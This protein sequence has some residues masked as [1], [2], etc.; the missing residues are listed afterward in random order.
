GGLGKL[1]RPAPDED[2]MPTL[3]PRAFGAGTERDEGG[4]ADSRGVHGRPGGKRRHEHR[5]DGVCFSHVA[6]LHPRPEVDA[7]SLTEGLPGPLDVVEDVR[8]RAA[9]EGGAVL[10]APAHERVGINTGALAPVSRSKTMARRGSADRLK[11]I[12]GADAISDTEPIEFDEHLPNGG[13][14]Q[15]FLRRPAV[16]GIAGAVMV[17]ADPPFGKPVNALDGIHRRA[18]GNRGDPAAVGVA[19]MNAPTGFVGRVDDLLPAL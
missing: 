6:H 19:R 1:R 13:G 17:D 15:E 2:V 8:G 18:L 10:D 14:K 5:P 7:R 16:A 4:V 3:V 11:D 9:L 12:L